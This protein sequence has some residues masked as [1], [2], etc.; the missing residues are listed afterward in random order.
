MFLLRHDRTYG[1][2]TPP[3]VWFAYSPS[4][5]VERSQ[6]HL[7][8]LQACCKPMRMP[9]KN[10]SAAS[11]WMKNCAARK[12][13]AKPLADDMERWLHAMLATLSR[14]TDTAA[15]ILYALKLWPALTRY[16]DD[17]RIE[18]DNSAAERALLAAALGRRNYLFGVPTAQVEANAPLPCMG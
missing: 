17:G 1:G 5:R 11:R 4:H 2:E 15:A 18:I 9:S 16:A 3:A 7:P 13:Q 10:P 14:K 8:A 12:L 6:A